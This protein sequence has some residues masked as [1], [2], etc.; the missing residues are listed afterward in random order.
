MFSL[1][2]EKIIFEKISFKRIT[3]RGIIF[4]GIIFVWF[5]CVKNKFKR[6]IFI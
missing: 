3:F 4:R 5:E 2:F 6:I 1:T